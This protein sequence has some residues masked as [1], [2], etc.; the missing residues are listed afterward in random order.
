ML[1]PSRVQSEP[2]REAVSDS[3]SGGEALQAIAGFFRRQHFVI[4]L[5]MLLAIVLGVI[6]LVTARPIFTGQ[7]QLLI[8][9]H[10][11]QGLQVSPQVPLMPADAA[12]QLESQVGVLKSENIG[13]AVI[14]KLHLNQD[15]EFIKSGSDV[16]AAI[17][18]FVSG[19]PESA[20]KLVPSEFELFRRAMEAFKARLAVTRI[21]QSNIIQIDFRSYNAELAAQVANAVADAYI[22][23]QLEAKYK[24]TRQAGGWLQDRIK[25]LRTQVSGAESA[26]V[27]FRAKHNIV[28]TGGTNRPLLNQQQITE[29]STQLTTTR[30]NTT[31]AK[32]RLDRIDSITKAG[33]TDQTLSFGAT[34]TDTLKNDIITKLWGQYLDMGA[35]ESNWSA[36]YGSDH[37]AVV[38][39]RNRMR[40][41]RNS[42]FA[43]LNRLGE[44]F[45]SDYEI[46]KQREQSLQREL[47]AAVASSQITDSNSIAL[48][49]LESTAQS[50]KTVYE[51]YLRRHMEGV[52]EES[53]PVSDARLI[54]P[55]TRPLRKSSPK[56]FIVLAVA[57]LIGAGLGFGI[58][59]WRDLSD[60][61]FRGIQ[62]VESLLHTTCIA[63]VPLADPKNPSSDAGSD[64]PGATMRGQFGTWVTKS[65]SSASAIT[66][67][68]KENSVPLQPGD[69]SGT[70]QNPAFSDQKTKIAVLT[71]SVENDEVKSPG[72]KIA[73]NDRLLWSVADE[74]LSRFSEAIRSIKLAVDLNGALKVNR[75]I[76]FTSTLPNEGKTTVAFSLAQLMAQ[77]GMRTILIDCDLR[78]PSLSRSLAPRARRG[79]IDVLVGKTEI[80]K[81]IWR[82]PST[83]MVFLPS[84]M[85]FRFANS[86]EILSS[87][88]MKKL[89][90]KLRE[91][92]DY[93]VVDLPPL[94][95]IV[96]ARAATPIVDSFVYVIEWGQTRIDVVEHALG[97]AQEVY[98]HLLGVVLNKVDMKSFSRHTG[99]HQSYYY[100][101]HYARYGYTD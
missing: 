47:D 89:F 44:S 69:P 5:A 31:E 39:L 100:N 26:V 30:A 90:D 85:K 73:R 40:E 46:A 51:N 72:R 29:L 48:T 45:K 38:N 42:I 65:L 14:N 76:G 12:A 79:L 96:D 54:S 9:T 37:F 75:V 84:I 58:G 94:A 34:V 64:S 15:P 63:L 13:S 28:S 10:Q 50:Y 57:G 101:K 43:E 87:E 77:V 35:L 59:M 53:F 83:N 22:V 67:T 25:E 49:E 62:Q 70:V 52:Q 11:L 95:P 81:A 99:Q 2:S 91:S 19:E 92:Y 27:K 98:D 32:A 21:P 66:I 61:V 74:P 55:A 68:S 17:S 78:N 4:L 60:R 3:I 18:S 41:I 16:L 82:D 8:D 71:P 86:S 20:D 97:Q 93:I 7:A 1:Q 36:K 80:E 6:Y 56:S 23:D 88:P 33:L 24:A